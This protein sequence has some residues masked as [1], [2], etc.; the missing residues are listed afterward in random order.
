MFFIVKTEFYII[1]Y[2]LSAKLCFSIEKHC[3]S[4]FIKHLAPDVQ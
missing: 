3:L 2:V 4:G 1:N